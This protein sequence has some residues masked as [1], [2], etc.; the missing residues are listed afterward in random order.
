M[1]LDKDTF[2]NIVEH[3]P[4]V[5]IELMVRND[6]NQVLLGK[7]VNEP[8]YGFWFVAGGRIYKDETLDMAFSR[9]V[10]DELGI[11]VKRKDARFHGLF[12]H[13][14]DNNVFNNNFSTHYVALAHKF[15]IEEDIKTNN[16]HSQYRWFD[17]EELLT[18]NEVHK[19][20]K[21]YFKH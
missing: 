17:V 4:L 7:R 16:Q 3:T 6:K 12:E 5:A 21:E 20:T 15:F 9:T 2:S 18:S 11:G 10:E 19:Y 14:Y 1:F 8:A 13:F